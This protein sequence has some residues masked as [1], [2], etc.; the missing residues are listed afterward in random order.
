M[1]MEYSFVAGLFDI[2]PHNLLF[3]V[4]N[5]SLHVFHETGYRQKVRTH[6]PKFFLHHEFRDKNKIK[7]FEDG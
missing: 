3:D 1:A 6:Y 7:A 5:G 2:Y 4:W